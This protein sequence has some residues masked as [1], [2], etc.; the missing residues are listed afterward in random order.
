MPIAGVPERMCHVTVASDDRQTG[1]G[2][3]GRL[4]ATVEAAIT[5]MQTAGRDHMELES[6][7]Q[8]RGL[9]VASVNSAVEVQA[10]GGMRV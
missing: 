8:R 9:H 4:V 2:D 1:T 6:N 5:N 3:V 7:G 10:W